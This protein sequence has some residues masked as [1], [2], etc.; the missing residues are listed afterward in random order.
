V[1]EFALSESSFARAL[2]GGLS[3][4]MNLEAPAGTYRLRTVV[5]EDG[6]AHV[7]ATTQAVELK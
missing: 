7:S 5:A 4:S 2:S 6:D 1:V 3:M